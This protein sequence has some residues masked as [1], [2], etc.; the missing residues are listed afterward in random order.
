MKLHFIVKDSASMVFSCS[1]LVHPLLLQLK[2]YTMLQYSYLCEPRTELV[3]GYLQYILS[4]LLQYYSKGTS[5]RT[6]WV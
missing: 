5:L 4:A 6:V 1:L 2:K 3:N